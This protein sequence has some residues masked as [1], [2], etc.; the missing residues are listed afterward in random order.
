MML[1]RLPLL[2]A[3]LFGV[4]N[5]QCPGGKTGYTDATC[6]ITQDD[7]LDAPMLAI[8]QAVSDFKTAIGDKSEAEFAQ[9]MTF[10]N[11]NLAVRLPALSAR[12]AAAYGSDSSAAPLRHCR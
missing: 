4:V 8:V 1:S 3:A 6:A 10:Y 5:G 9:A 7:R 2:A 12:C 11:A